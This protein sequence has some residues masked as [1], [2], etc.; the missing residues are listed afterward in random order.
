MAA[1]TA[2]EQYMLEMVNRARLD[3]QGEADRIGIDLNKDLTPGTLTGEARQPLVGNNYLVDSSQAHSQWMLDNDVFS[4]TGVGGSDAGTRM[5]AAGYVFAG[6]WTWGENIAWQGTTGTV[7]VTL[8]VELEHDGLFTSSGH[9]LNILQDSFREVGMGIKEGS[10]TVSDG[11]TY[12]SVMT[13][14]NFAKTGSNYFFTGAVYSDNDSNEFYSVGEANAGVTVTVKQGATTIV[15][16]ASEAAGGWRGAVAG[17][18]YDVTFSGGFLAAAVTVSATLAGANIKFDLVGTNRIESS[19]SATLGQNAVTLKLLGVADLNGT[20]N[21]LNNILIGSKGDNALN[22][23]AGDDF[24]YGNGG[25]DILRG[26]ADDD[27]IDGGSDSDLAGFDG[28]ARTYGIGWD[29]TSWSGSVATAGSDGTD[30]LTSIEMLSFMDGYYLSGNAAVTA[31][32]YDSA[33]NR[34][35]DEGGLMN[36]TASL[37]GG[38]SVVNMANGFMGSA[39]FTQTYGGLNNTQ[40][41]TLLYNNVLDRGPDQGGLAHWVGQLDTSAATRADIL[42]GFSESPEHIGMM[43]SSLV[44]SSIWLG[45]TEAEA[46]ARLYYA[47]LDRGPDAGGLYN[48]I[49]AFDNGTAFNTIASGFINSQEFQNVYGAL[50]NG[51]FVTLLYNNVLDRAPDSGGYNH[52]TGGLGNGTYTREDVV[53]GFSNSQEFQISTAPLMD[54]GIM[55]V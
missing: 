7:N 21:S 44:G 41:V 54:D 39:E 51:Q 14:Q 38:L 45:D 22:G 2:Y 50:N 19:A 1:T 42:Y 46:I 48:W 15:T 17:G 10:F 12:N 35:A 24:I 30:T 31:R 53:I 16:T 5:T 47:T 20:G 36:W 13:T 18:D 11:T 6:V 28:L 25:M 23:G 37:D 49:S 29:G 34:D 9:R 4:H 32:M 3:P 27:A 40:F 26:D 52:W 33:F 43:A 8:F 55:L